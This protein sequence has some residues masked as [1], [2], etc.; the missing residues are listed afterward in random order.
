MAVTD[1]PDPPAAVR[2]RAGL[3]HRD[4]RTHQLGLDVEDGVVLDLDPVVADALIRLDG[5]HSP[6]QA[7]ALTG[8]APG[9]VESALRAIPQHL[10]ERRHDPPV[11]AI[12]LLGAGHLGRTLARLW[13][14]ARP[15]SPALPLVLVDPDPP[16]AGL[17]PHRRPTAAECLASFLSALGH[18]AIRV[19]HH[20][21]D[22]PT[23]PTLTVLAVDRYECD[24]SVISTLVRDDQPHLVVRPLATGAIVGPLVLPGHSSCLRCA[25]LV[26]G[27][28]PAWPALLARATRRPVRPA[29]H[30]LHWAAATA[31]QHLAHWVR[32]GESALAGA[33]IE[34]SEAV[35]ACRSRRWPVHP[36]CGCHGP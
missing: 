32:T 11:H 16:P 26:R 2:L 36:D 9:A 24:R 14:T 13:C 34:Y 29:D 28:D 22:T 18:D 4:A 3:W 15:H 23:V 33:T 25:D 21:W 35:G 19:E 12:R 30:H 7:A 1:E 10:L 31:V 8:A 17:Y 20:W 6:A 5:R 27:Q